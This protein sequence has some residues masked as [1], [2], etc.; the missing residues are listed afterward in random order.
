MAVIEGGAIKGPLNTKKFHY[1]YYRFDLD[2]EKVRLIHKF[3]KIIS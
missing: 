1:V 2:A 3:L